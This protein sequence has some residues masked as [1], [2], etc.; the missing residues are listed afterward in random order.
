M[1]NERNQDW[2][3]LPSQ[4]GKLFIGGRWVKPVVGETFISENPAT[5]EPIATVGLGTEQDIELAVEAAQRAFTD[6]EWTD[7]MPADRGR[8]LWQIADLLELHG[9]SLARL[10]SWDNGKPVAQARAVDIPAAVEAFRYYAGWCTKI[11]GRTVALSI[12]NPTHAYTLREPV[13]V[14]GQIIPWNFPLAMAAWKLAPALAVGCTCVLKPAEQTS[15]SALRFGELLEESD[16]PPGVV[17]IVTGTGAVT[18][19]ALVGHPGVSKVAFTGSTAVG[20][21]LVSASATDLKRVS[22][23]LGGKSPAIIRKDADLQNAIAGVA[24]GGFYNAG[25]FCIAGSRIYAH[26]DIYD[27]VVGGICGI[28]RSIKL[29]PGNEESSDMGPLISRQQLDRVAE[30]VRSG[31]QD[32]ASLACGGSR[33]EGSGYYFEPTVLTDVTPHMKVQRE[34]IFGPVVTVSRFSDCDNLVR[35]AN[36]THYGLGASIW[37]KDISTAHRLAAQ[38]KAGT[39]WINCHGVSDNALPFGGMKQSGW[40]RECGYEAIELYTEVKSVVTML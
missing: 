39:V 33:L 1:S 37:T 16:L 34:E 31:I 24:N 4:C 17:N 5:G 20:K 23:E 13:G 12:P 38:I 8:L 27:E 35:L 11:E 21:E 36:D 30:M 14:V 18:G 29:G 2:A 6:S 3:A 9:E 15:L 19:G 26:D 10:E 22:L 40:G 7:M 28:A 32:G 25:Q